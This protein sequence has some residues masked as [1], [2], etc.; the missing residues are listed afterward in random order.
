[1]AVE[2]LVGRRRRAVHPVPAAEQ[3][4][5]ELPVLDEDDPVRLAAAQ[6]IAEA[7]QVQFGEPG[8]G[9]ARDGGVFAAAGAR[10]A[11]LALGLADVLGEQLQEVAAALLEDLLGDL[12]DAVAR[13][14]PEDLAAG[15]FVEEGE[16]GGLAAAA[17]LAAQDE[18]PVV[19]EPVPHP[20]V[21][22]GGAVDPAQVVERTGSPASASLSVCATS[23]GDVQDPSTRHHRGPRATGRTPVTSVSD[24]SGTSSVAAASRSRTRPVRKAS[25]SS[26]LNSAGSTQVLRWRSG[27][28]AWTKVR[29]R[30]GST[31]SG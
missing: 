8:G 20:P 13:V 7:V 30:V 28:V 2:D 15:Q 18:D 21:A 22:G 29:T 27:P 6:Q 12:V 4:V 19:A 9:T 11:R 24:A 14:E 31:W 16:R 17:G 26:R 5:G 10:G 23:G 3:P 1:M 25:A